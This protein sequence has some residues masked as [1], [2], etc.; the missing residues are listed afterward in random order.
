MSS[1]IESILSHNS[2]LAYTVQMQYNVKILQSSYDPRLLRK[3]C[4]PFLKHKMGALFS[5]KR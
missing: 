3:I 4:S 2:R 5:E 1:G